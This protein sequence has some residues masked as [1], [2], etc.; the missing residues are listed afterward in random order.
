VS[1][2]GRHPG[3]DRSVEQALAAGILVDPVGRRGR[4]LRVYC[5]GCGDAM[6]VPAWPVRAVH[7]RRRLLVF[8][9]VHRGHPS[10]EEA[11]GR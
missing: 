8:V 1:G 2:W 7:V 4:W 6:T 10:G 5:P 9:E 3:L 11:P